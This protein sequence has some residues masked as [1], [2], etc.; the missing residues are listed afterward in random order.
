MKKGRSRLRWV[1]QLMM[2]S[3]KEWDVQVL[4]TCMYPHDV[5]AVLQIRLS[6]RNDEDYLAWYYERSGLFSVRSAY[7]LALME[8]HGE[9]RGASSSTH[10]D[11]SRPLYKTIWKAEVPPKVK[12]FAWKLA[13]DG[14]ATNRNRKRHHLT[15]EATCQACGREEET[16]FHAMVQCTKARALRQ[17]LRQVW[18]LPNEHQLRHSGPDWLLLLLDSL[19]KRKIA[20]T[21]L[22]FR[23]AWHL[24]NY[25]IHGRGKATVK[26]S[27]LFLTSYEESLHTAR[28]R[29]RVEVNVK[30]KE[31]VRGSSAPDAPMRQQE[32]RK[33][34]KK[35]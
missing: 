15:G 11:G 21:L 24:R 8:E 27:A 5:E 3:R 10:P 22:L 13:Q 9:T 7:R 17:E 29:P 26:G 14:L 1:S 4:R 35:A 16:V 23:R 25:T 28:S 18:D 20:R 19:D 34:K 30:G 6:E 33:N 32:Q 2:P 31:K 12:I